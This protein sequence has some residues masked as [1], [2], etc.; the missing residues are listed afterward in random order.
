[1]KKINNIEKNNLILEK[2]VKVGIENANIE[3][4]KGVNKNGKPIISKLKPVETLK[5]RPVDLNG[6]SFDKIQKAIITIQ[7]E[8]KRLNSEEYFEEFDKKLMELREKL[9]YRKE[10]YRWYHF[11]FKLVPYK[12]ELNNQNN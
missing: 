8:E 5:K 9:N 1:M 11:F 2:P 10:N 7:S 12:V 4:F 6:V 3:I